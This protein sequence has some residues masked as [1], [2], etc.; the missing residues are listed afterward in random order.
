MTRGKAQ[1]QGGSQR[2]TLESLNLAEEIRT[3]QRHAAEQDG[4]VVC[5]GPLVFFSTET[6]DAWMLEPENH[7]AVRLARS[8]DPMTALF[9]ETAERFDIA[10]QGRFHLNGNMFV[11]E[12]NATGRVTAISGYPVKLLLRVLGAA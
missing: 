2:Q 3:I 4:R 12:D 7:L 6:G 11:Y 5:I 8:G 1:H 9:E 10:W